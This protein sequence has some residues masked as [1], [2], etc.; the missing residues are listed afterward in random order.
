MEESQTGGLVCS[1]SI[2]SFKSLIL[3]FFLRTFRASSLTWFSNYLM[4]ANMSVTLKSLILSC[5][6]FKW[7]LKC[8][9]VRCEF[10][11]E[12]VSEAGDFRVRKLPPLI[13]LRSLDLCKIRLSKLSWLTEGDC[14]SASYYLRGVARVCIGPTVM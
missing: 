7:F 2:V 4:Y 3:P 8:L 6:Y 1:A 5:S 11:S 9:S 13:V 14:Y 12:F 10:R